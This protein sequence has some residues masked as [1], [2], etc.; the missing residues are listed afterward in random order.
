QERIETNKVAFIN[1][2]VARPEFTARFPETLTAEQFV[3]A[4]NANTQ[5]SS[6]QA[7]QTALALSTAER[8]ALVSGLQTGAETRASVLRK[9]AE[10]T[11]FTRK[12]RDP[13][14]VLMQYFG[15]LRRDPDE[16]G[17]KFWLQKLTNHN[18]D[19]AS[20]QMVKAFLD[21]SEYRGRFVQ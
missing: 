21:S 19:Y 3:D 16:A 17:F 7:G 10:N 13:A 15:Y 8:D 4:L 6:A 14:F 18:G 20:A 11:E 2:F 5:D 12:Q 1:A 9:V